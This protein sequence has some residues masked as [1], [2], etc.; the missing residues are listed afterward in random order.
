MLT[1]RECHLGQ[2]EQ[3]ERNQAPWSLAPGAPCAASLPLPRL[4]P[5][6]SPSPAVAAWQELPRSSGLLQ[7]DIYISWVFYGVF[8][9]CQKVPAIDTHRYE[10]SPA[11]LRH[12]AA[13]LQ[14]LSRTGR[15]AWTQPVPR[16]AWRP[17]LPLHRVLST[18]F[19]SP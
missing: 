10:V 3:S 1:S 6:A 7:S 18:G 13:T 9:R 5:S 15:Q 14:R 11:A 8:G 16:P 4:P 19:A 12:L 17:R 2:T